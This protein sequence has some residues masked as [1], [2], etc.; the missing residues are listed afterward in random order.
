M[1]SYPSTSESFV[2]AAT[3]TKLHSYYHMYSSC[4][5]GAACNAVCQYPQIKISERWMLPARTSVQ[6]VRAERS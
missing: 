2:E 5:K 6:L 3:C 1:L 4:S